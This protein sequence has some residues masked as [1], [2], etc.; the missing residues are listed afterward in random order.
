[1]NRDDKKAVL[2]AFSHGHISRDEAK[3]LINSDLDNPL[4]KNQIWPN[5]QIESLGDVDHALIPLLDKAGIEYIQINRI[6]IS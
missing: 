5:G 1:M 6:I 2:K 4:F 3:T